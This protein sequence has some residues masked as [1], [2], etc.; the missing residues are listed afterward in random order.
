M[1]STKAVLIILG[2]ALFLLVVSLLINTNVSYGGQAINDDS[3]GSQQGTISLVINKPIA[4]S[5]AGNSGN[6]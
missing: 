4:P 2:I 1:V 3:E 6:G 5:G